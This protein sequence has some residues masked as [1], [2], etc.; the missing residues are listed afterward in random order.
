M[1]R[2]LVDVKA[3]VSVDYDGRSY[4]RG[5]W[6]KAQAVDALA[7]GQAGTV[8]L[9]REYTTR[10]A[11]AQTPTGK[12]SKRAYRRRDMVAETS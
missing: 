5:Q 8:S 7:M 2:E 1:N 11:V 6:F 3:L 10:S 9:T 12:P 4:R